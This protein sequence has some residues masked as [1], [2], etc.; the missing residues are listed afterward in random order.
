MRLTF[1]FLSCL[2]I[3]SCDK[4]ALTHDPETARLQAE[5]GD[6]QAQFQL[7]L[8]LL[9][10]AQASIDEAE[11]FT[12]IQ[13][14]AEQGY[15]PAQYRL[16]LMY[17][18]GQAVPVNQTQATHWY[19]LAAKQGDVDAQYSAG[20]MFYS[21]TGDYEADAEQAADWFEK[22]A[23]HGH[24]PAQRMLAEMYFAGTGVP[25]S[26]FY[27]FVWLTIAG[28]G[29]DSNSPMMNTSVQRMSEEQILE[30]RKFSEE[31]SKRIER[32]TS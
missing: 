12:W 3:A 31:L 16:G 25:Q 13:R 22:S 2:L 1:V 7:G 27:T 6:P 4:A 11:A 8:S 32:E 26:Y 19:V 5:R 18:E 29:R 30:A 15:A 24:G 10:R 21:G 17:E 9:E 14:S 23:N 20:R 28:S